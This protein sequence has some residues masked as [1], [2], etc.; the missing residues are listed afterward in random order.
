MADIILIPTYN[1]K[2]NIKLIVPEI[3]NIFPE[4]KILV[5]D[6]NS[7]DGTAAVVKF[8]ME[9]YSNLSLLERRHKTGLGDAYKEAMGRVVKDKEIRSIIT[10]DA[11]GSH[12]VEYLKDFFAKNQD[13]DLIIGSRYVSGGGVENWESWRKELS[14]FGNLYAKF[15][16]GLKI[17]DF[18]AGFMCINRE[19][20]EKLDLNKIGSSGYSFLIELKF[21]LIHEFKACV[22]EV[23]IIFKSRRE[24]ESK[25]SRQIIG[26]GIKAP[27]RLFLKRLWKKK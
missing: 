18:T 22:Y 20:L 7:P 13:Y 24:G 4:I 9:K 8:L 23:P 27:L 17:N 6:D 2:E 21:Y 1:E 10:M 25:I 19:F 12:S 14:R 11:D 5:I 16:T 15:L 3:F 26:E